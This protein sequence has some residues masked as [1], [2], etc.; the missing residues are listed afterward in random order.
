MSY[1]Y[2]DGH[3][4]DCDDTRLKIY[5]RIPFSGYWLGRYQLGCK[6]EWSLLYLW[7][8]KFNHEGYYFERV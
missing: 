7:E 8:K 5:F 1:R 4:Y 2:K 6:H 3:I